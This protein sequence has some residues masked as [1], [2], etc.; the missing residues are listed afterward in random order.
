SIVS[1]DWSIKSIKNPSMSANAFSFQGKGAD[2]AAVIG[3]PGWNNYSFSLSL[4]FPS[5]GEVGIIT[6]Y[7]GKDD[8]DLVSWS[9]ERIR[10]REFRNGKPKLIEDIDRGFIPGQW[11]RVSGTVSRHGYRLSVDGHSII[12]RHSTGFRAGRFGVYVNSEAHAYFDDA[13]IKDLQVQPLWA[14]AGGLLSFETVGGK[15][16][17]GDRE[18]M[19]TAGRDA[20][21]VW[22]LPGWSN[23]EVRTELKVLSK[24]RTGIGLYYSGDENY[25]LARIDF[26][27]KA[28]TLISRREGVDEELLKTELHI[29]ADGKLPLSLAMYNGVLT[30]R[31]GPVTLGNAF[32]RA[33]RSGRPF[34]WCGKAFQEEFR[35]TAV[36]FQE[37]IEPVRSENE[38]F[39]AEYSM[40]EWAGSRSDWLIEKEQYKGRNLVTLWNKASVPGDVLM[41]ADIEDMVPE[42]K[43]RL[44]LAA[45]NRRLNAGYSFGLNRGDKREVLLMRG[46]EVVERGALDEG[47]DLYRIGFQKIGNTLLGLVDD[48]IVLSHVDHDALLTGTNAG[49]VAAGKGITREDVWTYSDSL[50][51]YKF[52][53]SPSEW[54]VGSGT[55]EVTNRW[56]CDPRWTFF[57]GYTD[58]GGAVIWNK[59]KFEGDITVEFYAGIKMNREKGNK[60]QYAS[61][62]NCVIGGDGQSASSGYNLLFG[63]FK[64]SRSCITRGKE[65]VAETRDTVIPVSLNIHRRWFYI[66]IEKRGDLLSYFIDGRKILEFRDAQP[67]S[68]DRIGFWTYDNGIMVARVR[69]SSESGRQFESPLQTWSTASGTIYDKNE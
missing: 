25:Y 64:N 35:N 40:A 69:I 13:E 27:T 51:D 19:G 21:G 56:Q 52:T 38:I 15:W 66:R 22:G 5:D 6:G 46:E 14:Q 28:L 7:R 36:V 42:G 2:G 34:L 65:V 1:G 68:G 62:I 37:Y 57:S 17:A 4:N 9:A 59:R 41:E 3:E 63:G 20:K 26:E 60:Y 54:R 8:Y 12:T 30:V 10:L 44:M 67:L 39:T 50:F 53:R 32:S 61:D 29:P 18:V 48:R 16:Q 49:W 55:W 23:Y 24:G 11:Y 33:H 43:I 45:D 47:R 31:S 58:K